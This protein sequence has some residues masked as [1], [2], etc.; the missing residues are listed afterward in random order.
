MSTKYVLKMRHFHNLQ[1]LD[2][3]FSETSQY[4]NLKKMLETKNVQ[5]KDLR[6]RI[7][8]F[9]SLISCLNC[10]FAQFMTP[11][12]FNTIASDEV[13]KHSSILIFADMN[14]TQKSKE[15]KEKGLPCSA[16]AISN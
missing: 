3:K 13:M 14:R 4:K 12:S 5:I 2:K 15:K 6:A 1:E 16:F 9:F 8:R 7:K 10:I 11:H